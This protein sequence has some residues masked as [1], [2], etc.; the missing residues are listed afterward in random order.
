M[1]HPGKDRSRKNNTE[2]WDADFR[3]WTQIRITLLIRCKK[4]K[5]S[6]F[7][8]FLLF[9][10]E[11]IRRMQV[12][13]TWGGFYHPFPKGG[14]SAILGFIKDLLKLR[15]CLAAWVAGRRA[16]ADVQGL[17]GLPGQTGE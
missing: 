9:F 13:C 10:P 4:P 15:F 11:T 16:L 8:P 5:H 14:F 3:G 6:R 12:E 17:S 7:A 2:K 1:Y